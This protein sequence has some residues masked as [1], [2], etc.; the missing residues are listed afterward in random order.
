MSA[1]HTIGWL[2]RVCSGKIVPFDA[3]NEEIL[4]DHMDHRDIFGN[5]PQAKPES[6]PLG[7][8]V[9]Y[10]DTYEPDLLFPIPRQG[11]RAEIAIAGQLPFYGVDV[12]N[13]YEFSWLNAKGKPIAA[14]L[15]LSVPCESPNL[16]ESKSLKLYLN[17]YQHTK[18]AS[19][20][21]ALLAVTEDVSTACGVD[22]SVDIQLLQECSVGEFKNFPGMCID[23]LDIDI[24]TYDLNPSFLKTDSNDIV[25]EELH[26]HILKSNCL[27][28]GQPD[29]G[30]IAISYVGKKISHEGLLRYFVSFRNHD[31]FAEHCV[32][33][34]FM[35][36]MRY[37]QPEKL[38]VEGRYT[39]R[40]GLDI[41]PFRTT[42]LNR[43]PHRL[44]LV[45]Q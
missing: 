37:C 29:W 32:E 21:Q 20:E 15:Q 6:L 26:S 38:M 22:V 45:R 13:A 40:G 43:S 28:T 44:R 18:F 14:L 33:R 5:V 41:N 10:R 25:V 2:L 23:D 19:L 36:L 24:D 9:A 39:R 42:E 12:W 35:D 1:D 7:K 4:M 27:V 31:E 8:K 11:K 16:V 34:V 30:S 17:S 3:I